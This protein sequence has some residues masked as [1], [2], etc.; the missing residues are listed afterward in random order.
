MH[1]NQKLSI[2]L[3]HHYAYHKIKDLQLEEIDSIVVEYK[4]AAE[5]KTF[6][7]PI[8]ALR[9]I[10][11]E[12]MDI[13]LHHEKYLQEFSQYLNE[14]EQIVKKGPRLDESDLKKVTLLQNKANVLSELIYAIEDSLGY[15]TR[16]LLEHYPTSEIGEQF[17]NKFSRF[18]GPIDWMNTQLE[19]TKA[20]SI[21]KV[22]GKTKATS[23]S[24]EVIDEAKQ[25]IG[26]DDVESVFGLLLS[27]AQ[28][29]SIEN[30]LIQLKQQWEENKKSTSLGLLT[31]E[32]SSVNKARI[33]NG[34]LYI[35]SIK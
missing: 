16:F 22:N 6:K 17:I 9:S 15:I 33:V 12:L 5:E 1:T 32:S 24:A 4:R 35:I 13:L 20:N 34:L 21:N 19:E 30:E 11:V 29:K 28:D 14:S 31:N 25:L 26:N 7:Q 2:F 18:L 8:I 3:N 27:K 23:F 10:Q